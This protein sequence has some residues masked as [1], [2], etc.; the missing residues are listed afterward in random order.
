[1][2]EVRVRGHGQGVG[3][4]YF[5]RRRRGGAKLGRELLS[6]ELLGG[7][8]LGR[9]QLGVALFGG[10]KLSRAQLGRALGGPALLGGELCS[11]LRF[12]GRLFLGSALPGSG[13]G[14]LGSLSFGVDEFCSSRRLGGGELSRPCLRNALF[15]LPAFRFRSEHIARRSLAV[16]LEVGC[17]RT[18][19]RARRRGLGHGGRK[20]PP[21]LPPVERGPPRPAVVTTAHAGRYA[22]RRPRSVP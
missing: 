13:S 15:I 6:G 7:E 20:L 17:F 9:A 22:P 18:G 1:M 11:S 19:G 8:R 10:P 16:R 4:G 21:R 12:G 2:R 5:G 14:E 3:L